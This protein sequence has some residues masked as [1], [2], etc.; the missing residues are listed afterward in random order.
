MTD[1]FDP[2]RDEKFSGMKSEDIDP[3][4]PKPSWFRPSKDFIE[5]QKRGGDKLQ[6]PAPDYP[7]NPEERL[8]RLGAKKLRITY[9]CRLLVANRWEGQYAK[10]AEHY[11][12]TPGVIEK[13]LAEARD[14]I[15]S[16]DLDDD[17]LRLELHLGLASARERMEELLWSPQVSHGNQV[18]AAEA[19]N[20]LSEQIAKLKGVAAPQKIDLSAG[21]SL[22]QLEEMRRVARANKDKAIDT[23]AEKAAAA[24]LG[25]GSSDGD[26]T[27]AAE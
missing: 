1:V 2:K 18:R 14:R 22:E 25:E 15:K 9:L 8:G 10:V 27:K 16:L 23:L 20:S 19:F 4:G 24:E 13:D 21:V 17:Q 7:D 26:G 5:R 11:G 3:D 6:G 12:V